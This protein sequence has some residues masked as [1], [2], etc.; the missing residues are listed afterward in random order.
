MSN[1][2]TNVFAIEKRQVNFLVASLLDFFR[3]IENEDKWQQAAKMA[4]NFIKRSANI[5]S[6]R[7][8]KRLFFLANQLKNN[9]NPAS[10]RLFAQECLISAAK[11]GRGPLNSSMEENKKPSPNLQRKALKDI[12]NFL[13]FGHSEQTATA[14]AAYSLLKEKKDLEQKL[15]RIERIKSH[16]LRDTLEMFS[17]DKPLPKEDIR[18]HLLHLKSFVH[19]DNPGQGMLFSVL[20]K[21]QAFSAVRLHQLLGDD[22]FF[23]CRPLGF[24]DKNEQLIEVEVPSSAHLNALTYRKLELLQAL[25]KDPTFKRA[26]NIKLKVR[27]RAF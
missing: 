19:R 16:P 10:I 27:F 22:L 6:P 11:A 12:K 1:N 2:D 4:A 7:L 5:S 15:Q 23:L 9:L 25:K 13:H 3:P 26:Q 18:N 21:A 20:K 24:V 17:H 8:D 14:R